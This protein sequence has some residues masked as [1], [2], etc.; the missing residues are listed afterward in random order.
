MAAAVAGGPRGVRPHEEWRSYGGDAGGGRYS[1]LKQIHRDNVSQLRRAWTYRHGELFTGKPGER[2]P[3]FECTPIVVDGRLYFSTPSQRIIALDAETG[4]EIW[5]FDPQAA[6]SKRV[7]MAHRGVAYWQSADGKERRILFGTFDGRLISLNA[8][9]GEPSRDF[10]AAG[11][12][13]LR[14]GI[15]DA[16]PKADYG[17]SSPPAIYRD[18]IIMGARLPEGPGLGPPGDVRA[19]DVRTGRLVWTFHTV[20]R[21][22]EPG[23]ETW[24]GDSWKYR[25]GVNVWSIMSVDQDR[26]L[27]YL[28]IGSAAADFYGGDRRG[29]NLYANSLV[30]LDAKTGKLRWHYQLVHH[31]IWDYDPPAQPNLITVRKNGKR[32]PAV[33]Q[34]T[35]MGLVFVFDRVTG[36]PLFPIEERPVPS[37]V[38]PGEA[39]WPTQPFPLKP[40]PLSRVTPVTQADLS[41]VTPAAASAAAALFDQVAVSGGLYTPTGS[42]LTLWFPGT[43]GGCTWSGACFDPERQ[44]YFTNVN[45][46]GALGKMVPMPEGSSVRFRRTSPIGEYARFWDGKWPAQKPPWGELVAVDLKTGDIAW[47]IPLGTVP[48]LNRRGLPPTGTPNLGGS[49]CTAGGLVFIGGS[50]DSLFRAFDSATGKILWEAPLEASGHA[51]PLTYLGKKTG[52][53]YVVIAAGGG[54]YFSSTASDALAAYALP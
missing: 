42:D 24:E 19:F 13:N 35:K 20:P 17:V 39:S 14:D 4:A 33:A 32:I 52:R 54:G 44:L 25:T 48:E 27:V 51:T 23:H 47:R 5:R 9:N 7:T 30:C 26:G 18:L 50:S 8:L 36:K 3:P 46:V 11:I 38:V 40:P 28:P 49:I 12:I 34:V 31:D 21:P 10:G 16:Y 41:D 29:R 53:Q 1:P 15:A 2:L 45:N 22:G 43:L 6:S 37:S